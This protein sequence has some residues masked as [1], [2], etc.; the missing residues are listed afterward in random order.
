MLNIR[1]AGVEDIATIRAV[2]EVSFRATYADILSPEQLDYMMDWMYSPE[3]LARQLAGGHVFYLLEETQ[4]DSGSSFGTDSRSDYAAGSVADSE[5]DSQFVSG[6]NGVPEQDACLGVR[7]LG[8]VSV[9]REGFTEIKSE[10]SSEI[11]G[12]ENPSVTS[13]SKNPS[14]ASEPKNPSKASAAAAQLA[15]EAAG[16]QVRAGETAVTQVLAGGTAGARVPL[17]HLQKLYLLPSAQGRGLGRLLFEKAVA[18]VREDAGGPA[19]MELNVN[20]HNRAVT[21]YETMGMHKDRQG[22]FAIGHDYY[23]NDYIMRLEL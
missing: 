13:G 16:A 17:Y 20:R 18:H 19:V 21:F 5:P 1:K 22:D 6:R 8:Y 2:A 4:S 14:K 7:C 12:S 15:G 10:N 23:M 11:S 9:E 3:S